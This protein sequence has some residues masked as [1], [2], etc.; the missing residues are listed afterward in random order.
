MVKRYCTEVQVYIVSD[1]AHTSASPKKP[2]PKGRFGVVKQPPYCAGFLHSAGAVGV[3]PTPG[4]VLNIGQ[5]GKL[6]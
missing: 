5:A 6:L 4:G 1:M 3:T 2:P